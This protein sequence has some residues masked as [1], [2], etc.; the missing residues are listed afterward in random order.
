VTGATT[1]LHNFLFP[2]V[3]LFIRGSGRFTPRESKATAHFWPRHRQALRSGT[4]RADLGKKW[5]WQMG[6]GSKSAWPKP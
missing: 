6:D 1:G 4:R 2:C 3:Q 5:H